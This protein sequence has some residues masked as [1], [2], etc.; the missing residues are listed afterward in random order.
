MYNSKQSIGMKQLL[1]FIAAVTF[2]TA[3]FAQTT[4]TGKI[5]GTVKEAKNQ[6]AIGQ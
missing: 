5:S 2:C 6:L 4:K 3:G 1:T